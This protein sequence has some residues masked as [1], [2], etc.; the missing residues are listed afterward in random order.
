[1]VLN[2][3]LSSIGAL[4]QRPTTEACEMIGQLW[5]FRWNHVL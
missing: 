2:F 4:K 1:M 5:D 3:T